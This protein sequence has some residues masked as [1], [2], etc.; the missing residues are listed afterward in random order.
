MKLRPLHER[1]LIERLNTEPKNEGGILLTGSSA[2]KSN[3]GKVL[4]VG[5]GKVLDNGKL[6]PIDLKVG[7]R[8]LFKEGY[9]SHSEQQGE[10]EFLVLSESDILAV[11]EE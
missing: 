10:Q 2:N 8:V 11:I 4:A 7:D 3:Q 9:G 5:P 1:V 6:R